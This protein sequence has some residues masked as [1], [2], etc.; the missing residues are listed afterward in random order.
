MHVTV[1]EICASTC[2]AKLTTSILYINIVNTINKQS[3]EVESIN[4]V[5]FIR[6]H[7]I[8]IEGRN[9]ISFYDVLLLI[10]VR[11]KIIAFT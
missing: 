1:I 4:N 11:E 6:V 10:I 3:I 8:S 2:V 9:G 7:K 5:H